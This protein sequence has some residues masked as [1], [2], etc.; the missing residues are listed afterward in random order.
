MQTIIITELASCKVKDL[1]PVHVIIQ[2]F[3]V[4]INKMFACIHTLWEVKWIHYHAV[5]TTLVSFLSLEKFSLKLKT[6][7]SKS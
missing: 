2:R 3:T 6:K 7:F 5:T 4:Y 1:D